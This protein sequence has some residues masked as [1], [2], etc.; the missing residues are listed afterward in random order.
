MRIG[1]IKG[2]L[3]ELKWLEVKR[4]R[5]LMWIEKEDNVRIEKRCKNEDN[6]E[7]D[8]KIEGKRIE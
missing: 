8:R 3:Y 4:W 7:D 5:Q 2:V 1:T 6:I